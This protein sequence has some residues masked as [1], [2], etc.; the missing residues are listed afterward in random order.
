MMDAM[1]QGARS[2][3]AKILFFIL[4]LSFAV[5]GIADVFTGFNRG[6]LATVG[7]T[8]I[9]A[10][11]FQQ[12][13]QNE[14]NQISQQIGRRITPEQGRQFGL[15]Q[16]TLTRLIGGAAIEAHARDLGLA[17]PDS[18]IADEIQNEPAF[19]GFDGRFS[20]NAFEGFLRQLGIS[21]QAFIAM[22]RRDDVRDQVINTLGT[23]IAVPPA[24]V[25][26]LHAF[27]GETRVIEYLT[28]DPAKAVTV[29]EPDE[30]K[31]KET[32]EVDKTRFMTPEYRKLAVLLLSVDALKTMT[33]VTDDEIKAAFEK[34]RATFSVPEKRRIQQISFKDKAAAEA[35]KTKIAGGQSFVDAAK[36]AGATETDISLG[37]LGKADLIDPKI[38]EVTFALEQ[39]KVSDVV[40]GRFATVLLRVTEIQQGKEAVFDEVKDRLR[41]RLA[42]EKARASLTQLHD[43]VD[44]NR[45]AGKSLK[46]IADILKIPFIEVEA[47]D[48]SNRTPDGKPAIEAA[49]G[50]KIMGAGFEAQMGIERD[51][52]ELADG[53]YAWVDLLGITPAEQKP[54][55]AVKDEV[56]TVYMGQERKKALGELSAKLVDRIKAGEKL[57]D[58]AKET[59]GKAE[60]TQPVARHVVPQ[61]LTQAAMAQAFVLAQGAAGATDTADGA[62]RIVFRVN[63]IRP[64]PPATKEQR[65]ALVADLSSQ[66]QGDAVTSYVNALQQRLGVSINQV[67]LRRVTGADVQQ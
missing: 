21:E 8:T 64:A 36:E 54:F 13:Y 26:A 41:E 29:A 6:S 47:G 4:I 18:T 2:W 3:I 58:I 32:Y 63:E 52:V 37:L 10:N 39:D 60:T 45:A 40:E 30:A 19:Q 25:D 44:D 27:N 35:A 24:M 51:P 23:A 62:T 33:P 38:A 61:G 48:R 9:S 20:R 5:W 46:E 65:E 34:E 42:A 66:L 59:G 22:K 11:D 31:L 14:L 16:R 12:A 28:L 1:R 53:G 67:E 49:E 56:K 55:E 50:E 15:D 57:E 17:I 43:G 7:E